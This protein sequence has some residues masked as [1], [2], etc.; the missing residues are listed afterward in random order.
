MREFHM[1]G[2]VA[3]LNDPKANDEILNICIKLKKPSHLGNMLGNSQTVT[4]E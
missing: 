1:A 2:S 4:E 3:F